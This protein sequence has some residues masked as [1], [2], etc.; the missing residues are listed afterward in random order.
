MRQPDNNWL[1]GADNPSSAL[2]ILKGI[3][4]VPATIK[5]LTADSPNQAANSR[6]EIDSLI[7]R[8]HAAS[9]P[10][11]PIYD[12]P[13]LGG[14]VKYGAEPFLNT[15]PNAVA[16]AAKLPTARN[17]Q[18]GAADVSNIALAPLTV[19]GLGAL[20]GGAAGSS[21]AEQSLTNAARLFPYG[22]AEGGLSS[23][24]AGENM[25][26]P[27]DLKRAG[28]MSLLGGGIAAA[29]GAAAPAISAGSNKLAELL[30]LGGGD[31]PA[32]DIF[33]YYYDSD[34]NAPVSPETKDL[35]S[36]GDSQGQIDAFDRPGL[37]TSWLENSGKPANPIEKLVNGSNR[38]PTIPE[39][40]KLLGIG[41]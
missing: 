7:P 41:K 4:Q 26:L 34:A 8:L 13:V 1:L 20:P 9:K 29:G 3:S 37:A 5:Q 17:F 30:G 15:L 19:A 38:P 12:T 31:S 25:N 18:Q 2:S 6:A 14:A 16:G 40:M 11:D 28:L 35:I 39:L 21:L 10:T 33:S 27:D 32:D 36:F 24:G 22:A 23:L